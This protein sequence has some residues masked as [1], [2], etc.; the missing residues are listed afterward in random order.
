MVE[1]IIKELN[2]DLDLILGIQNKGEENNNISKNEEI[3]KKKFF[4][5]K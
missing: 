5:K 1:K 3:L 4:L 2:G